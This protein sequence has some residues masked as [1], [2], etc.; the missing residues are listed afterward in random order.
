MV[1]PWS[2]T[3]ARR[4]RGG[5]KKEKR[6]EAGAIEDKRTAGKGEG[7][8]ACERRTER[9]KAPERG[10]A[11]P[12]LFTAAAAAAAATH[13]GA[14]APAVGETKRSSAAETA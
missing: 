8:F 13:S 3:H 14:Q 2:R 4:S 7:K 11:R 6:R 5:L 9:K 10:A 1:V 12:R